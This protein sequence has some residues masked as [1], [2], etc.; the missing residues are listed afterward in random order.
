MSLSFEPDVL[1]LDVSHSGGCGEHDY[2]MCWGGELA[3]GFIPEVHIKFSHFNR[4]DLCEAIVSETLRYDL[5]TVYP[6]T[7][8]SGFNVKVMTSPETFLTALYDIESSAE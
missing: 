1:V 3:P 2:Q 4:G 5:T 8:T 6:V 7:G